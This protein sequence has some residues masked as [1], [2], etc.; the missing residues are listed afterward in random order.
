MGLTH[1]FSPINIGTVSLKNRLVFLPHSTGFTTQEGLPS[2]RHAYYFAERAKG[3]VGLIIGDGSQIV[4]PSARIKWLINAYDTAVIPGYK[5]ITDAVH[6]HGAR[7]FSQIY[8]PGASIG[9]EESRHPVLAPSNVPDIAREVPKPMDKGDIEAVIEGYALSA[10]NAVVGGYDGVEL[11]AGSSSLI[12]EFLSPLTNLREDEYGGS[13]NARRRFAVEV[14]EAVRG[15]IGKDFVLGL[16]LCLD[17]KKPGGY[18]LKEGLEVGRTLAETRKI[19]YLNTDTAT[20]A[21]IDLTS[22][23]TPMPQGYNL[24]AVEKLKK[25]VRLPVIASGRI[26]DPLFAEEV[27]AE[28]KADLI[29]MAR[30]LIADPETPN[31]A[32]EGRLDDIR[33][34]VGINQGCLG[35]LYTVGH[36]RCVQNPAV[37]MEKELGI[38]TL[39]PAQHK[40]KVVIVGG[41]PAG[42]KAAEITARR[43]HEVVLFE[44]RKLG[45]QVDIASRGANRAEIAGIT[46]YLIGQV[47]KLGVDIRLGVEA[48]AVT[49][50]SEAP[51]AV[52]V[53]NGARHVKP[54]LT[55]GGEFLQLLAEYAQLEAEVFTVPEVLEGKAILGKEVAVFDTAG[56]QEAA[57]TAELIADKGKKVVFITPHHYVGMSLDPSNFFPIHMRF[58]EKGITVITH[59]FVKDVKGKSVT[60]LNVYT[61]QERMIK[62]DSLV[63]NVG[64]EAED[65]LYHSLKGKVKE[66]HRAG[67]CVSPRSI[68]TAIWE[69]ELVGRR[70]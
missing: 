43:G 14:I 51:D 3:G 29:G 46:A 41:G 66:L 38:G 8:H 10:K 69:G 59:S 42:L 21:R 34:C 53:S 12:R 31:K 4:H 65:E 45:G 52:V 25:A 49:I 33:Y 70:L 22:P 23:P 36:I 27:L 50:T 9:G 17:E 2:E 24:E 68:E 1:L 57:S 56:D 6:A 30:Q 39:M 16:R 26:K 55:A 11:Q 62:A 19:D 67:D 40:K 20:L 13:A 15:A 61:G 37:G 32:F 54:S 5:R 63:V 58:Y 60:I 28:G 48:E 47:Q 18:G 35:G 7:I 44:K 64:K